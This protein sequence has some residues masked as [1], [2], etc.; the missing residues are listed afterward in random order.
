MV[1]NRW[2]LVEDVDPWGRA[3]A[4][5]LALR[6]PCNWQKMGL[7]E[8]RDFIKG[9]YKGDIPFSSQRPAICV[10][11]I[12]ME[13][14]GHDWGDIDAESNRRITAVLESPTLPEVGLCDKPMFFGKLHGTRKGYLLHDYKNNCDITDMLIERREKLC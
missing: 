2:G 6:V 4:D 8:R 3:I 13:L 14:L 1:L 5:Y 10:R 9:E 11:E 7:S 12:W